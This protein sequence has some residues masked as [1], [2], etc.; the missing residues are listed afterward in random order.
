MSLKPN[1]AAIVAKFAEAS[2]L[3]AEPVPYDRLVASQFCSLLNG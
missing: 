3:I 2:G 1:R